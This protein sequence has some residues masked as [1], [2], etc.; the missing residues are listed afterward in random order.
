MSKP[1]IFG[2]KVNQGWP[3]QEI[4]LE[5]VCGAEATPAVERIIA[6]VELPLEPQPTIIY[7]LGA[8][9]DD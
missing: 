9:V 4:C 5:T 6:N 8:S 2:G 7:I 1:E 3:P